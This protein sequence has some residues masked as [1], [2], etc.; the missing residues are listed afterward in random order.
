V[1]LKK[2]VA[3]LRYGFPGE[4]GDWPLTIA[5]ADF[6]EEAQKKNAARRLMIFSASV[7]WPPGTSSGTMFELP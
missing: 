3:R 2:A 6:G 4:R 1:R 7:G 5:S